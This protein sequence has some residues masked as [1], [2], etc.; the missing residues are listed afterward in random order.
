MEKDMKEGKSDKILCILFC[1]CM[2]IFFIISLIKPQTGFSE[3]ENRYLSQKPKFSVKEVFSGKYMEQYEAYITDQFPF[4]N[5]WITCKTLAERALLK[6]EIN[7]IYFAKDQYYMERQKKSQLFAEQSERNQETL[8]SFIKQQQE[9]LGAG[10]VSVMLVPTAA[11]VLKDKLPLLAPEDGQ[12]ELLSKIEAM[13][14]KDTWIDVYKELLLHKEEEIFY[15]T[16][17]HWTTLGAFYAYKV[18]KEKQGQKMPLRE[19]YK[20]VCLSDSFTGTLYAKVNVP[21]KPDQIIAFIKTGEVKVRL[22]MSGEWKDSL[23]FEERLSTRDQYAVFCDGNHAV[24]EI[25]TSANNGK[26]LL[27]IKDSYAHCLAPFFTADFEKITM[28]DLRYYNGSIKSY[29]EEHQ[30]TDILVVYNLAGFTID[31]YINKLIK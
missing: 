16:D 14:P 23:Y 31:R 4:R 28:L 5:H 25:E 18:W 27:I 22:D 1:G 17:H 30:I 9:E 3:F 21:M 12:E 8:V 24:T 19:N 13:L 15:R 20:E 6:S 29:I 10:H 26:N 7:G 2:S 11:C